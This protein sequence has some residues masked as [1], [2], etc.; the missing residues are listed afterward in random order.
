LGWA[1]RPSTPR[2]SGLPR[3]R[4]CRRPPVSAESL[5]SQ[6]T[7]EQ[8]RGTDLQSRLQ[9][10]ITQ[11]SQVQAA[12]DAANARIATDGSTAKAL[13]TQIA[14]AEKK[15]AALNK[16]AAAAALTVA[17]ARRT[18]VERQTVATTAARPTTTH[19]TTGASGAPASGEGGDD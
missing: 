3:P 13:R 18:V 1:P 5:A 14:A 4:R 11:A 12:L 10:A 19:A 6:L 2:P 16:Q 7:N 17:A 8:A 15:L 9:A